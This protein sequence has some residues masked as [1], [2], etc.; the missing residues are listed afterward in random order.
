MT[1]ARRRGARG[2][3]ETGARRRDRRRDGTRLGAATRRAVTGRVGA[4]GDG[5]AARR[6]S[7]EGRGARGDDAT[8]TTMARGAQGGDG[9]GGGAR[10]G[11]TARGGRR[12]WCVGAGSG[13]L[14]AEMG[15]EGEG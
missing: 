7:G 9:D 14:G 10:R 11:A 13:R 8:V 4:W 5:M 1:A 6:G 3:E 2:G 12:R 15:E